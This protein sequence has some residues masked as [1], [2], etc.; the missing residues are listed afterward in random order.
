M[1][2]LLST[3]ALLVGIMSLSLFVG[4][5]YAQ[6]VCPPD[7]AAQGWIVVDGECVP[8]PPVG[9]MPVPIDNGQ[10]FA[11]LIET[12]LIWLAPAAVGSIVL[13]KIRSKRN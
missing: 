4:T 12:N 5:S 13:L 2:K 6:Q 9:G 1:N 8:P 7:L 10:L 3:L 11:G